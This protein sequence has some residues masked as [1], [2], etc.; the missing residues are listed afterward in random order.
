LES[1]WSTVLAVFLIW[2]VFGA[3]ALA[4]GLLLDVGADYLRRRFFGEWE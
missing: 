3:G 2:V 1:D 4:L